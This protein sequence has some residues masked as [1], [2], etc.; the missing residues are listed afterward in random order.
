M[1]TLSHP[2]VAG[3]DWASASLLE[4]TMKQSVL[5]SYKFKDL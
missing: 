2:F 4:I 1:D 5:Q 3:K